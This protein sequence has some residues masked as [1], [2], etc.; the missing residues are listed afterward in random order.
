MKFR[1]LCILLSNIS[2]K[3]GGINVIS[4]IQSYCLALL[5]SSQSNWFGKSQLTSLVAIGLQQPYAKTK[6]GE[7]CS[8]MM[9]IDSVDGC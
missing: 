5:D 9:F 3:G 7:S 1:F 2:Q 8:C 4:Y 6:V